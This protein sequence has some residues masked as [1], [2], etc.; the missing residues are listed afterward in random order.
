MITAEIKNNIRLPK[1]TLEEDLKYIAKEIIVKIMRRNIDKG[2]NLNEEQYPP[3]AE[4]T[5]RRKTAQGL[6]KKV[7]IATGELRLSFLID[8][9][10][11]SKIKI[12][13]NSSR[14]DI[15]DILQNK[16]VKTKRG[17]RY[18]NFFGVSQ[19]MEVLAWKYMVKQIKEKIHKKN[20]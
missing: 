3:L 12:N 8:V 9:I 13:L 18:F 7:L 14:A 5:I 10:S 4:S 17:T 1:L 16:G 19:R 20:G 11:S 6:S 2:I 15:G